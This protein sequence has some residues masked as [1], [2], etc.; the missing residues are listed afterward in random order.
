MRSFVRSDGIDYVQQFCIFRETPVVNRNF[1]GR[2]AR[3]TS[4]RSVKQVKRISI[5]L[6]ILESFLLPC[7]QCS[8]YYIEWGNQ[9][10]Q[11]YIG[12]PNNLHTMSELLPLQG[13]PQSDDRCE[14]KWGM[15]K[16]YMYIVWGLGSRWEAKFTHRKGYRTL[17]ELPRSS[18]WTA[19]TAGEGS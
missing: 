11:W 7:Q 5:T 2:L 8:G 3:P 13:V 19:S 6:T 16:L 1:G 10:L 4:E 15:I 17:L 9:L 18:V 12:L 14:E